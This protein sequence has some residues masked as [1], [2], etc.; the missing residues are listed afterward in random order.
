[1]ELENTKLE[2]STEQTLPVQELPKDI[3]AE[4]RKKLAET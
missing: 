4:V 1:M 2:H 3:P